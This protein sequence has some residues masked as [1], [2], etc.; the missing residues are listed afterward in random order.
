MT[1][2]INVR[3]SSAHRGGCL[4]VNTETTRSQ[5]CVQEQHMKWN[6]RAIHAEY[7]LVVHTYG[8]SMQGLHVFESV[9]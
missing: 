7:S 1:V 8:E 4:R 9:A 3:V 6:R 5:E 2:E